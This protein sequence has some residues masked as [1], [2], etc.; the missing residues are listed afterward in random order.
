MNKREALRFAAGELE[1]IAAGLAKAYQAPD[2]PSDD[3][4]MAYSKKDRERIGAAFA[5][6]RF[7]M[8]RTATGA[9]REKPQVTPPDPNQVALFE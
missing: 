5:E 8:D 3:W 6:L 1:E 2:L 7:R 4:R 9:Q